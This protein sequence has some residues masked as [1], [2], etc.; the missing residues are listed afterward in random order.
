MNG[1]TCYK[2]PIFY[3]P[4]GD[5][6]KSAEDREVK[7][8]EEE[9]KEERRMMNNRRNRMKKTRWR[10]WRSVGGISFSRTHPSLQKLS[11]SVTTT[12]QSFLIIPNSHSF[13]SM[14]HG[15]IAILF[16]SLSCC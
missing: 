11:F 14:H 7:E 10:K 5:T 1:C 13:N 6:T 9:E 3:L 4:T 12:L 8:E 2:L 16:F 15:I